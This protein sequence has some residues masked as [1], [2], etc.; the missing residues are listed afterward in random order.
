MTHY[1]DYL[2]IGDISMDVAVRVPHLPGPDEKMWLETIGTYPGGMGA[3]AAC[4]FA[5]LGGRAGLATSVGDDEHGRAALADLRLRGVDLRWVQ[6]IDHPTFWTLAL[7]TPSGE[8]TLLEF[9]TPAMAVHWPTFDWSMLARVRFVHIVPNDLEQNERVLAET[10][11]L[12]A[13]P[14]LDLEETMF[15]IDELPRRLKNL[16]VLLMNRA[17]S[18]KI[19]PGLA[20]AARRASELGPGVVVITLGAEGCF[21]LDRQGNE[22]LLCGHRVEAKDTTG[23]GDCFAGSFAF[24]LLAGWAEREAAELANLAAA[25]S[26]TA[27]GSR[28]AVMDR[29]LLRERARDSGFQWWERIT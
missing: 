19:A 12:G 1:P 14:S 7:L 18:E 25:I 23:A 29:Q 24:G 8:K 17:A 11:R 4:A 6:T 9:P 13:V 2:A 28:E 27:V 20:T 26:T 10:R 3:N 15:T 5:A 16:D 21:L 22:H